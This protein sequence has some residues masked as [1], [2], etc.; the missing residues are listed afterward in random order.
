MAE[1]GGITSS[2]PGQPWHPLGVGGAL[3]DRK[4][5]GQ[6]CTGGGG[7]PGNG[8]HRNCGELAKNGPVG[9]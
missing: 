1:A 8:S 4:I 2:L 7:Y 6:I 9:G 3:G 5:S